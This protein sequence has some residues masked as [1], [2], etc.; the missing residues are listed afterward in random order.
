MQ[1]N[2]PGSEFDDGDYW[3]HPDYGNSRTSFWL[4]IPAGLLTITC[5][6]LSDGVTSPILSIVIFTCLLIHILHSI[7]HL[8]YKKFYQFPALTDYFNIVII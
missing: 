5:P 7:F 6:I 1:T 2:G 3:T 4:E 8:P